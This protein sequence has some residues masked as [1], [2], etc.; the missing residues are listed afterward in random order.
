M[1]YVYLINASGTKN[2]KI[3]STSRTV[4]ERICEL[5]TGNSEELLFV[6]SYLTENYRKLEIWLHRKYRTK[7][8]EGEWFELEDEE[9]KI[10]ENTCKTIDKT[11]TLL[12][13]NNPFFN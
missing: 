5:Q 10:F 12:L 4:N 9:V 2:Y 3:G 13:E 7:R 8:K 1:G 11:I 6:N